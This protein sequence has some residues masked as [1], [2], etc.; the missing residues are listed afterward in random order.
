M[1]YL[2]TN[3][4]VSAIP[5]NTTFNLTTSSTETPMNKPITLD[6]T[7]SAPASGTVTLQWSIN[8]SVWYSYEMNLT[9]GH[10]SRDFGFAGTGNWTFRILWPGNTNY[11][12]STSNIISVNVLPAVTD[13]EADYTIY[14]IIAAVVIVVILVIGLVFL[15]RRKTKAPQ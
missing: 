1:V 14:I 12:A 9:N 10:A 15:R 7:L 8:G 11:S 3:Q 5:Q 6:A 2:G 4:P 13:Q